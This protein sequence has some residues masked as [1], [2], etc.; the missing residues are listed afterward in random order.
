MAGVLSSRE[1]TMLIADLVDSV[2]CTDEV[3][4]RFK[5]AT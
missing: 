4:F 3:A 5:L 1:H 2:G